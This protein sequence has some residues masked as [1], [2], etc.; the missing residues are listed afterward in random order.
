[1]PVPA[2]TKA[3][4]FGGLG[5]RCDLCGEIAAGEPPPFAARCPRC[6][7]AAL[8]SLKAWV[9]RVRVARGQTA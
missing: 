6:G 7:A 5:W 2:V 4:P 8:T 1:M 9:E 3:A